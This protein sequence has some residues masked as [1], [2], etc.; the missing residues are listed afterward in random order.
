MSSG[1]GSA[2]W[3]EQMELENTMNTTYSAGQLMQ[4]A[5]EGLLSKT[6]MADLLAHDPQRSFLHACEQVEREITQS[7]ADDGHNCL[8]SGCA[9][10]GEACLN[11]LLKSGPAYHKA[12]ARLWVPLFSDAHN[13]IA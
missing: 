10:K 4:R 12:C 2:R 3:P 13:R 5:E 11:A 1:F 6:E 8:E 7:C 9:M